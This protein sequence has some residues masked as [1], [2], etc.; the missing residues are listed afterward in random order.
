MVF[1]VY[2]YTANNDML[3]FLLYTYKLTY[4]TIFLYHMEML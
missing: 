4:H 2:V 3:L 1:L